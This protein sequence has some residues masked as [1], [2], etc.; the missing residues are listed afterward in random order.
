MDPNLIKAAATDLAEEVGADVIL[1]N[2]QMVPGMEATLKTVLSSRTERRE[3]VIV[4]LVTPGGLADVA[5][6]C[7]R[8]LQ[9]AYSEITCCISGWCKSAGTLLAI[10]AHHLVM[11]ADGELGPLDVQITKKD[12]IGDRDSGLIMNAALDS[13]RGEAFGFFEKY[14]IDIIARSQNAVTF[15]TAAEIAAELTIGMMAP[16]FDKI[17]P[18]RLGADTRAMN[19]GGEYAKRLNLVAG[20]L[21]SNESL[22]MILNGY[23][24]HSFVIDFLEA[25]VL[26]TRVK[27]LE[28]KLEALVGLL[29]DF[30]KVPQDKAGICYLDHDDDADEDDDGAGDADGP[31]GE[32]PDAAS[33]G[34][35]EGGVDNAGPPEDV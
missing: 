18:A 25:S 14:M 34:A 26:F 6:R 16:V 35:A 24:S 12:A 32:A 15:R 13:L 5:Y 3:K 20:N 21:R 27:P 7:A 1:L 9:L 28:G 10:G 29:G 31:E 22:N 8:A 30:A 2:G 11:G 19:I 23:P 17:D 33:D 4:I